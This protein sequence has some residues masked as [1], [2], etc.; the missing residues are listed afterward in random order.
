MFVKWLRTYEGLW[1]LMIGLV[2]LV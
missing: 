2:L 1:C